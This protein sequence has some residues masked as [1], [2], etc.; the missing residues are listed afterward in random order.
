M[1]YLGPEGEEVK[2]M[3]LE[4][5]THERLFRGEQL[6]TRS[7]RDGHEEPLEDVPI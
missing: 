3:F 4:K 2:D 7:T 1:M 5:L 6:C